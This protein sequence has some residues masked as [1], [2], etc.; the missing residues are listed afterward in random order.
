MKQLI[1]SVLNRLGY[2]I[3]NTVIK[4]KQIQNFVKSF[5]LVNDPND[6]VY[7]SASDLL[8]IKKYFPDLTLENHKDGVLARFNNKLI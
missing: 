7:K 6:L 2:K 4:E 1:H 8:A 5:G 3:L